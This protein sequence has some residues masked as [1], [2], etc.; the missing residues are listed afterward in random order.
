MRCP[1]TLQIISGSNVHVFFKKTEKQCA[2]CMTKPMKESAP[3]RK[4]QILFELM[5]V[6]AP[7]TKRIHAA[8]V[9]V[10]GQLTIGHF[11]YE[12]SSFQINI[13]KQLSTYIHTGEKKGKK[14]GEKIGVIACFLETPRWDFC[15]CLARVFQRML[16][17]PVPVSQLTTPIWTA[18]TKDTPIAEP[19]IVPNI[20]IKWKGPLNNTY[21]LD[22]Q[23]NKIIR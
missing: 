17:T 4:H 22:V 11:F 14:E 6:V 1:P 9:C 3:G 16:C 23:F 2:H 13:P 12:I 19:F 8:R 10:C 21:I 5:V 18:C 15:A 20:L 7:S